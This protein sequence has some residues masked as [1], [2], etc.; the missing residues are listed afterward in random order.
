MYY[1]SREKERICEEGDVLLDFLLLSPSSRASCVLPKQ[2]G[3]T[4][5]K[6]EE[7]Y[8]IFPIYSQLFSGRGKLAGYKTCEA[9]FSHRRRSTECAGPKITEEHQQASGV[10]C[11]CNGRCRRER[12]YSL[13]S[14]ARQNK[15]NISELKSPFFMTL[16]LF[17]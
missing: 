6:K 8:V 14:G 2:R 17:L 5:M 9:F 15:P 7:A 13:L 10:D 4:Q 12:P 11:L 3:W 16:F 1:L